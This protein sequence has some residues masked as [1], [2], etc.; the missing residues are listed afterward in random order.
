MIQS[1]KNPTCDHHGSGF[2]ILLDKLEFGGQRPRT[3]RARCSAFRYCPDPL[4][5]VTA[6]QLDKLEFA[7]LFYSITSNLSLV[8]GIYGRCLDLQIL[9][10]VFANALA[11]VRPPPLYDVP[12]IKSVAWIVKYTPSSMEI[13]TPKFVVV[14]Q[15]NNC[16]ASGS[17]S[18]CSATSR[19][20]SENSAAE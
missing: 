14:N 16:D 1:I 2:C 17:H 11:S 13:F 6:E 18:P 20:L 3:M 5:I 12:S 7:E 4:G 19:S 10:I 8:F 9:V 15:D